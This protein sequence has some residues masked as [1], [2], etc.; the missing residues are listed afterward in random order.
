MG[1]T[2]SPQLQYT[3][4]AVTS[5]LCQALKETAEHAV[6]AAVTECVVAVPFHATPAARSDVVEVWVVVEL[7]YK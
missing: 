3:A 1:L 4:T 5:M 2:N 6:H 7:I